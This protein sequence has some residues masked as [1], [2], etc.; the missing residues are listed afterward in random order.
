MVLILVVI[1]WLYVTLMMAVAEATAI[2]GTVLGALIT[3]VV[4]GLIPMGIILYIF[5]TPAR[6]R[7]R[8]AREALAEREW[9]ATQDTEAKAAEASGVEPGGH[10][11]AA[12]AAETALIAPVRKEP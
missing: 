11:E 3:F 9:Q 1:A 5:G 10:S 4:Y 2:N 12:T 6:K 7:A 8:K